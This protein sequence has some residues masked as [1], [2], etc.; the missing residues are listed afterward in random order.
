MHEF[1]RRVLPAQPRK[2]PTIPRR[3]QIFQWTGYGWLNCRLRCSPIFL[4]SRRRDSRTIFQTNFV[5]SSINNTHH[6]PCLMMMYIDLPCQS[7]Y[8]NLSICLPRGLSINFFWLILYLIDIKILFFFLD[9]R[10]I[11]IE[12]CM[13]I[14]FTHLIMINLI[15]RS[16]NSEYIHDAIVFIG[17]VSLKID[18]FQEL[19]KE[20]T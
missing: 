8:P 16:Y 7:S 19:F 17:K 11:Q 1:P 13:L 3:S 14:F 20:I 12:F 9:Y 10:Y 4:I 15:L 5:H 2:N 6:T 18:F